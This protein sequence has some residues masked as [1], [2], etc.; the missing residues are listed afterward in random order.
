MFLITICVIRARSKLVI[1]IR[2]SSVSW[3]LIIQ[4]YPETR[5]SK[6]FGC[7]PKLVE[8][9]QFSRLF[10]LFSVFSMYTESTFHVIDN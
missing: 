2:G 5:I 3:F 7:G 4:T 10:S 9:G 6:I 8:I 1:I